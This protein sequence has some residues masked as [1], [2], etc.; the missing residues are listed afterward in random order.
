MVAAAVAAVVYVVAVV[1]PLPLSADT[2]RV[3]PFACRLVVRPRLPV[4]CHISQANDA[5]H[6]IANKDEEKTTL[7]GAL[8]TKPK[9]DKE[10]A[11]AYGIV[12]RPFLALAAAACLVLC[13]QATA[14]G[15]LCAV[16]RRL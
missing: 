11:R 16:W 10:S 8:M 5:R 6:Q 12:S 4:N 13:C 9:L 1:R 15:R 7:F 3:Y 14:P 2:R